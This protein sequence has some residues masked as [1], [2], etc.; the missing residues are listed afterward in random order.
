MKKVWLIFAGVMVM[1]C[2]KDDGGS[3][4][5][6]EPP[7][8]DEPVAMDDEVEPS[9]NSEL[10]MTDLLENDTVFDYARITAFDSETEEGGSVVDN[11]DGSL[12]YT[13]PQDFT[14]EDSFEYTICDNADTPNCSSATV[15]ITVTASDPVAHDDSYETQ[16]DTGITLSNFLENDELLDNATV[17]S[18]DVEGTFGEVV[19]NNDGTI[20][21][22]PAIGFAG[23]D[24]FTYTICDDDSEPTCS[25]AVISIT[26]T[27]TGSPEAKDDLVVLEAGSGESIITDL[28]ENDLVEDD[29]TITSVSGAS[30]GTVTLGEGGNVIYTPAIGF[31]GEDSF[32]YTLCDDDAPDP[33]CSEAT[34]EV[35]VVETVAF[36]IPAELQ[37]YYGNMTF[38]TSSAANLEV[39]SDL[40]VDKHTTILSYGQRHDYLYE[41]DEDPSEPDNVILMYTGESR[42][43][44]EYQSPNN[45][46]EPQTFNTEHIY[47]QSKLTSDDAVTDLHHLRVADADIN[48]T[49]LNHPFT[50]GS[51]EA[52]LVGGDSWYPGDEWK[53][54]VARMV[55]YLH[56]RYGET[57]SKVG[58][59]E[60]FLEWNAEDPVSAFEIQRN[61]VISAVQGNRNPFIDNPYLATLIWGGVSAENRW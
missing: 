43:W 52:H 14:G 2:S 58:N 28:L 42:F 57:V 48:S 20:S 30:H 17:T 19:L 26:V 56:I 41:A 8:V 9:E 45:P 38:S 4:A 7:A 37:T 25:S 49:R 47:P 11:R 18:V 51:G 13:P 5:P 59:L 24:T 34:V 16:E 39:I 33:T 35:S 46:Y 15:T 60:L 6:P 10:V 31:T 23:Q 29:A 55:M 12:T 36:D 44:K 32:V 50:E 53:G 1:G 3:V 21:Y 22:E 61:E 27:D 40:T 54:D